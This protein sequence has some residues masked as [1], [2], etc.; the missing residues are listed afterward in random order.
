MTHG[1]PLDSVR[2]H[3]NHSRAVTVNPMGPSGRMNS[4]RNSM[5]TSEI[6]SNFNCKQATVF[7]H[8][9]TSLPVPVFK[10]YTDF[11]PPE[12]DR[13]GIAVP[14]NL[15][16]SQ[17]VEDNDVDLVRKKIRLNN[18]DH[19]NFDTVLRNPDTIRYF[20]GIYERNNPKHIRETKEG[21]TEPRNLYVA[22]EENR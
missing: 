20:S 21:S 19:K 8:R 1:T 11:P 16:I 18:I 15:S 22:L 13:K 4:R 7:G 3:P 14:R 10:G 12:M 6:S 5:M 9:K 17:R 2:T